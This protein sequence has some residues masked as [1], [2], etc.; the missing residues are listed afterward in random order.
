MNSSDKTAFLPQ[1]GQRETIT[2]IEAVGVFV[3]NVPPMIIMNG[4]KHLYGWYYGNMPHHW[5]TGVSPN[6]MTDS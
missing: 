1:P 3:Q 4:E 2:V 6:G 5:T